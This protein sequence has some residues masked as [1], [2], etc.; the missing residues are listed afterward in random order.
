M[1]LNMIPWGLI[2][3]LCSYFTLIPCFPIVLNYL[4][5]PH[6]EP[7]PYDYV[8]IF[9][10]Q[11]SC[12]NFPILGPTLN[13][14][15]LYCPDVFVYSVLYTQICRFGARESRKCDIW[16]NLFWV[17]SLNIIFLASFHSPE[18]FNIPF[19]ST[20]ESCSIVHVKHTFI[21]H[22]SFE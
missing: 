22:S 2:R 7:W 20:P 5:H 16:S 18:K 1:N 21:I 10:E 9:I 8:F 14:V 13:M 4:P 11:L 19:L 15:P 3:C 6:L 12:M 17:I